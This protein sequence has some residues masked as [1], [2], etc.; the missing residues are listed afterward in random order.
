M[1][2]LNF[3]HILGIMATLA[4]ITLLGIYSGKN[5]RS[6]SDFST[7]SRRAN[8]WIIAGTITGTLVGGASTIGTA[9][10]AY[11]YG[12]SA[13]WFTLGAG[14]GCFILAF[15]FCEPFYKANKET[16]PQIIMGEYGNTAG[17]ISSV[18]VSIGIFLNIVAQVLAAIALITSMF[19][20]NTLLAA[21][22]AV[23]LMAAYVIFGGV[24]GTG[25]VGVAKLLLIYISLILGGVMAYAGAGGV[26]GLRTSLPAFP[27]FS[28]FG[29]GFWIDFSAGFS[30]IIGVLSTQT[31]FQ[32]VVSGKSLSE[33]RK[34][35]FLSALLIPPV[36]IPGILIGLYMRMKH[37]GLN[38][39]A[40]FP[41][42]VL[43][44]FNPW[45][46]EVVLATLL[47][48]VTGTGAG[49]TL[50]I[51]TIMA[52]DIYKYFFNKKAGDRTILRVT[53]YSIILVLAMTLIFISGN[54]KSL[55]LKWSFMSMGLRGA[56]VFAPLCAALFM[57]GKVNSKL[58][59][60][61]MV[62][63]PLS[64]FFG[65]FLLPES[66]DPLLPGIIIT[67]VLI[68][69]GFFAEKRSGWGDDR[70]KKRGLFLP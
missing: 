37:P 62:V 4:G 26:E 54:I 18:F 15:L 66:V 44:Y 57:P 13:W 46:G 35:A 36:G 64:V 9:Q 49:L 14:L 11:L 8:A 65:R 50:G 48:A 16:I 17:P 61:A 27:Y 33:A 3:Q 28:L 52:K 22:A 55:I 40:A 63:G 59:V 23:S 5:I 24:W 25:I 70:W 47:I 53:R 12:L 41:Q 1:Y 39:A 34:G 32:A 56:T 2:S 68:A 45:I 31:Y 29:R 7:G 6:S 10:L 21:I 30:L 58:A 38:P 51:S 67:F 19:K 43:S 20:V 69:I 60:S 42:F